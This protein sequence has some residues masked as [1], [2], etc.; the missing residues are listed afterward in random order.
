MTDKPHFIKVFYHGY[1]KD[2]YQYTAIGA[3]QMMS[4][5]FRNPNVV[6]A[7]WYNIEQNNRVMDTFS[8]T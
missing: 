5:L 1:A 6:S 2:V 4:V 7:T 3:K 8:R